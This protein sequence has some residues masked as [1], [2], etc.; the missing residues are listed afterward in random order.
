MIFNIF[1]LILTLV[2]F[3]CVKY[4]VWKVTDDK[5][6]IPRFLEYAPYSCSIC[7]NFWLQAG[8]YL[9]IGLICGM[10]ITM[11]VGMA[12]DILDTVAQKVHQKNNTMS[13]YDFEN[14]EI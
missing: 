14:S 12:L 13:A 4:L 3:I 5:P 7:L 1:Q 11:G 2:I 8:I 9:S 10:Y 6:C